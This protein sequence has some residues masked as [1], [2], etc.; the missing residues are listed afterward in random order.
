[1]EVAASSF[2]V[3]SIA[4][5]LT[6][7]VIKLIKFSREV[8]D[9]LPDIVELSDDLRLFSNLLARCKRLG[10]LLLID[11]AT[12]ETLRKCESK[13]SRLHARVRVFEADLKSPSRRKR[14]LAAIK[15]VFQSEEIETIQKSI[16]NATQYLHIA[17]QCSML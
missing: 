14:A 9:A 15:S 16:Y 6:E 3:I 1:M 5:Q 4:G 7:G 11:N 17:L 8:K 13:I 12:E 10:Q 2:A